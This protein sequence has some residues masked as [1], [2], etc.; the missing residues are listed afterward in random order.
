[1]KHLISISIS[2][3]LLFAFAHG[4][5]DNSNDGVSSGNDAGAE[6]SRDSATSGGDGAKASVG[7]TSFG[8]C[9]I[10][11]DDNPW[12]RDISKDPLDTDAMAQIMPKMALLTGVH[13]DWGTVTDHYGI[14]ITVGP[15]GVPLPI[16]FNSKYGAS[17]SDPLPCPNGGGQFCYPIPQNAAIEGGP[18]AKSTLD[19][20]VLFLDT[21]G[22]PAHCSL[23]E[24]YNTQNPTATGFTCASGA[25]FHLDTNAL[26]PE[27][28][29]SA[30]AAG[31]PILPGLVRFDEVSRGEITHAIRFTMDQTR[32]AYIHPATHQAGVNDATLPPMGL[33]VRLKASFDLSAFTGPSLVVLKAMQKYGLILADNGSNWYI[34]GES[35]EGWGPLMSNL[36]TDLKKATGNDFEIVKSGALVVPPIP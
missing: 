35:N 25:I 6:G 12:D 3:A 34:T 5:G 36:L 26:R 11:P 18:A 31:L 33:R 24:L 10:F 7:Q 19:R 30:D 9:Q 27:G 21:S 8:G 22:A 17:E 32:A 4:C 14:P 15:G 16:S 23:Y 20:H 29:T 28:W 13:P 1:M 2:G